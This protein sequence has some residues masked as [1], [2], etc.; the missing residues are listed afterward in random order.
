MRHRIAP[1]GTPFCIRFQKRILFFLYVKVVISAATAMLFFAG[2]VI[3]SQARGSM[4][5]RTASTPHAASYV[6]GGDDDK[7]ATQ[8]PATNE[9]SESQIRGT[10]GQGMLLI[11]LAADLALAFLVGWII[12]LYGDDDFTSW[13]ELHELD[14]LTI[15]LEDRIAQ[16]IGRLEMDK[17]LCFAGIMRA[18]IRISN[19]TPPY[20]RALTILLMTV[21]LLALPIRAQTVDFYRGILIDTSASI[22]RGGKLNEL[23]HEYLRETKK[24]LLTEPPNSVVWVVTISTD[25]FGD[26]QQILK[27][28]TPESHGVFTDDLNR[29][30]R[31]LVSAFEAKSSGMSPVTSGTDIL[32]GLWRLK[33]LIESRNEGGRPASKEVWLFSDMM[34]ETK[35][36]PMPELIG[37]GPQQMLEKVKAEGLLIPMKGYRVHICGASTTGMSPKVWAVVKDF[38]TAYFLAVGAELA[39]YSADTD[40]DR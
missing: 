4:L 9:K 28:Q 24:L 1:N 33:A 10:M 34:N 18:A 35:E 13:N 29:A 32:G 8:E 36:F 19:R 40:C 26:S 17:K 6:D 21:L 11:M 27:G 31:Q 16:I 15:R 5:D 7:S 3:V 37:L 2:A 23:F 12:D 14:E 30:R 25:S 22:S 20:H 39:T 38:W